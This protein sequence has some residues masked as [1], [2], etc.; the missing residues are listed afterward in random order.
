HHF[1]ETVATEAGDDE[2]ADRCKAA[3]D[4]A[5]AGTRGDKAYGLPKLKENFGDKTVEKVAELFNYA[6]ERPNE[7]A[8]PANPSGYFD[9]PELPTGLLPGLVERFARVQGEMTGADPTGFAVAALTTCAAAIPDFITITPKRHDHA[10]DE[11]SR[12]WTMIIGDP[13]TGRASS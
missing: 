13:S 11:S 12:L 9:P 5:A 1:V 3:A 7:A 8:T 10:W 2:V 4:S 6:D